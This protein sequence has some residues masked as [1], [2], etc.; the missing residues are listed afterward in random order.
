M[1]CYILHREHKPIGLQVL[2]KL[3]FSAYNIYCYFLYRPN[4]FY[5]ICFIWSLKVVIIHAKRHRTK[6]MG[7]STNL[8][9]KIEHGQFTVQH[10]ARL[11]CKIARWLLCNIATLQRVGY[12]ARYCTQCFKISCTQHPIASCRQAYTSL[13]SLGS[14]ESIYILHNHETEKHIL[15]Y[16]KSI[17]N[18]IYLPDLVWS[19]T[20]ELEMARETKLQSF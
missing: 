13:D 14:W 15:N 1:L 6:Q 10:C 9:G 20:S 3:L 8:A 5:H 4:V 12:L 16:F 11:P 2:I 7:N 18:R 17:Q 19:L